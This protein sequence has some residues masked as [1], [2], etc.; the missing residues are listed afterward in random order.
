M[1]QVGKNIIGITPTYEVCQGVLYSVF[2]FPPIC[3][4]I[5]PSICWSAFEFC[6]MFILSLGGGTGQGYF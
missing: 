5:C 1:Q 3:P 4:S 2:I 6:F